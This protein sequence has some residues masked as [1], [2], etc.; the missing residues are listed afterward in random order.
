M[1][2]SYTTERVNDYSVLTNLNLAYG[3]EYFGSPNT[4]ARKEAGSTVAKA[5]I[6]DPDGDYS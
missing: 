3:I 1:Q 4:E 6:Q 5:F 2:H